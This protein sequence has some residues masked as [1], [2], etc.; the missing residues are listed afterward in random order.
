MV[1]PER[2]L[3]PIIR[4]S[5]DKHAVACTE[6]PYEQHGATVTVR[7]ILATTA[8]ERALTNASVIF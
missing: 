6:I 1:A 4:L 8:G 3:S 5:G 2:V 7:G